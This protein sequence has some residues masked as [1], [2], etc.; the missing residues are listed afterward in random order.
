MARE[1]HLHLRH[2]GNIPQGQLATGTPA[3]GEVPVASSTDPDDYP[4]WGAPPAATEITDIPTAE[5]DTTKRLAPDGAG[6]VEWVAGGGGGG[7][8]FDDD[9]PSLRFQTGYWRIAE[10]DPGTGFDAFLQ[11]RLNEA[12]IVAGDGTDGGGIIVTGTAGTSAIVIEVSDNSGAD[13]S[14]IDVEPT[15]IDLFTAGKIITHGEGV[16][17]PNLGSAPGSPS[18]GQV[19][20]DTGS[21]KLRC[22]DGSAWNDLW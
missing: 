13:Y 7:S 8:Q 1:T 3:V 5:T 11:L 15:Y 10:I 21:A 12:R 17:F 6:A 9:V 20:F 19:Y 18:A 22:W 14:A 2:R 16:V 4:A